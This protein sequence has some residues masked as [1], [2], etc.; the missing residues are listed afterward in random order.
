LFTQHIIE[1]GQER[2]VKYASHNHVHIF[3]FCTLQE[4]EGTEDDVFWAKC[5]EDLIAQM[6]AHVHNI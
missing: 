1:N 6:I 3:M 2:G 5:D 4:W